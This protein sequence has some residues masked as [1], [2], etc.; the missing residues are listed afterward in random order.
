MPYGTPGEAIASRLLATPAVVALVGVRVTPSKPP[1]DAPGDYL[2]YY[3]SAGGGGM[4][5]NGPAGLNA[6]SMRV[7][8]Y[9]ETQAGAEAILT[10]V[11]SALGGWSDRANGVQGCFAQ[12][13]A[14]EQVIDDA[15]GGVYQV[16]GQSFQL[17]YTG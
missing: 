14:D 5:L 4:R 1:Q 12:E 10:A 11:R 13:D 9:S 15:G 16:S 2:V 17:W 6:Y 8:C 7:D 3:R